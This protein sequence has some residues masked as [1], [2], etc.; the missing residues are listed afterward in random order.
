MRKLA[1]TRNESNVQPAVLALITSLIENPFTRFFSII[2]SGIVPF[3]VQMQMFE[4]KI[5]GNGASRMWS[6]KGP[7][8]VIRKY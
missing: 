1:V 2:H 7:L 4:N 8:F 5:M 3:N 6:I